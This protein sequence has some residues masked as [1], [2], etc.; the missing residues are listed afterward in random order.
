LRRPGITR[1]TIYNPHTCAITTHTN[2]RHSNATAYTLSHHINAISQDRNLKPKHIANQERLQHSNQLLYH[3]AWRLKEKAIRH[4]EGD[5]SEQFALLPIICHY[6][7]EQHE[8]SITNFELY[9]DQ[10]FHR[11][12][13]APG[14]LRRSFGMNLRHLIAIDATHT[15]SRMLIFF[16]KNS[17]F[18][19]KNTYR[20]SDEPYACLCS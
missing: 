6:I 5:Q 15:T 10:S 18:D 13:I 17:K 20:V 8:Y 7:Q 19:T 14:A 16:K 9:P 11:L 4:I 3:Q 2:F 1:V 12:F